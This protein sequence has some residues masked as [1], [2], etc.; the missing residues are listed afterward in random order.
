[1]GDAVG[2]YS[3]GLAKTSSIFVSECIWSA[4]DSPVCII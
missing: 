3:R 4:L 1:V 2:D